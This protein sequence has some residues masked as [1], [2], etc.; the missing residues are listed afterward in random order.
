[1]AVTSE[2]VT[3]SAGGQEASGALAP[4]LR[5]LSARVDHVRDQ[6][7]FQRDPEFLR[8]QLPAVTRYVNY[9]SP[10]VRG[11]DNCPPAVRRSWSGTIPASSTCPT[12]GWSGSR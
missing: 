4:L 12:P 5:G 11:Q 10:E 7:L 1:M 9:F 3:E 8:R 2:H 6:P